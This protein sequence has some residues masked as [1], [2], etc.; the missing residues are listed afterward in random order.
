VTDTK[1]PFAPLRSR[2]FLAIWIAAMASNVGTWVQSVGEKWLMSELSRSP[3]LMSLIE[4]GATLPMLI[5]S[6]PGGAIAD[7]VDRRK[8]L[9]TTQVFMLACAA[10]LRRGRDR[11][12]PALQALCVAAALAAAILSHYVA[13][14]CVPLHTTVDRHGDRSGQHGVHK[15]WEVGLLDVIMDGEGWLPE[16]RPA[17]LG[18]DPLGAP[19]AW[20]RD[21]FSLVPGVLSDDLAAQRADPGGFGEAYWQAFGQSQIPHVKEQ[22]TLAGQRTA[23]MILLAWTRAG[24]PAAP[25]N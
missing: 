6:M 8:L 16:V 3:L 2:L 15:R 17:T 5:L 9:I 13:D 7:I 23:R 22:L 4:T 11:G 21:S 24:S 10:A 12:A 18:P 19:W 25:H 20:L 1:S 14:L